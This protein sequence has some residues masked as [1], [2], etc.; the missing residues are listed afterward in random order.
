MITNGLFH[1]T[2]SSRYPAIARL[3]GEKTWKSFVNRTVNTRSCT[4]EGVPP[5]VNLRNSMSV[6]P[7]SA[8]S[9]CLDHIVYKNK[10]VYII[11][12]IYNVD[13]I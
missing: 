9:F 8:H 5:K 13:T 2:S 12:C 10:C 11:M 3:P 6:M 1:N 7:H 4:E